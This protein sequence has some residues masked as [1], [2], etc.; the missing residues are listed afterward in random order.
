MIGS[1]WTWLV[2]CGRINPVLKIFNTFNGATPFQE[3]RDYHYYETKPI[4]TNS[5]AGPVEQR[6]NAMTLFS[7][8]ISPKPV[9]STAS[10]S[11]NSEDAEV[12]PLLCLPLWEHAF[13]LDYKMD[14]E[15]YI[16][17]F[18][19]CVNW[20]RIAVILNVY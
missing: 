17:N 19:S 13:V 1:G 4:P 5:P 12:T 15:R 8:L 14:K 9:D 20:N 11:K 7:N 18:W 3:V 16:S 10:A 2:K 6:K